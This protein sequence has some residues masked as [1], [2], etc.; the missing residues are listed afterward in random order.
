MANFPIKLPIIGSDKASAVLKGVGNSVGKLSGKVRDV[1]NKLMLMGQRLKANAAV[2][3]LSAIGGNLKGIGSG[4]QSAVMRAGALAAV[5]GTAFGALVK[6]TADAGDKLS[7]LSGL[8]G[9]TVESLQTLRFAAQQAGDMTGE[10]FDANLLQFTKRLGEAKNGTGALAAAFKKSSPAFF[11]Q[12]TN[13]KDSREALGLM[14]DAI[15]Q[16]KDPTQRAAMAAAAFGKA[17]GKMALMA[18]AGA[19][20]IAKWEKEAARLGIITGKDAEAADNF[21]KSLDGLIGAFTGLKNAAIGPLLPVLGELTAKLGEVFV[22]IR[23]QLIEFTKGVARDLPGFLRDIKTEFQ[24]LKTTL[25]PIASTI[26]GL[27]VKFGVLKTVF[28]ALALFIAGPLLSPMLGL[29]MNLTKLAV[30]VF[31]LVLKG[32]GGLMTGLKLFGGFVLNTLMPLM[33]KFFLF[34]LT[35]PFGQ[36][37]LA[38]GLL[39]GAGVLLYQNWDLVKEKCAQFWDFLKTKFAEGVVFI[40]DK[41]MALQKMMPGIVKNIAKFIP[42]LSFLSED[43]LLGKGVVAANKMARESLGGEGTP[44]GSERQIAPAKL[45]NVREINSVTESTKKTQVEVSF[46]NL[47]QGAKVKT[48]GNTRDKDT[49]LFINSGLQGAAL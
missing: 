45:G 44:G 24:S 42:G 29:S 40:T 14:L 2:Q 17:G 4:L 28:A 46:S 47:P 27:I 36:A 35:N 6:S 23:P 15:R 3:N 39:V 21:N 1:N 5:G 38:I 9:V 49:K 41:L 22:E 11:S 32:V 48:K 13:A 26:G 19:E 37:A 20:E 12:I 33:S 34:M 10:E 7:E 8:T 16:V 25:G 18:G 31:P 43:G 30:N